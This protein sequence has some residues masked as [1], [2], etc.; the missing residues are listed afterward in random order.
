MPKK[1]DQN[2]Q[3][4]VN[5][6]GMLGLLE[7][8]T[9]NKSQVSIK[10]LLEIT[11]QRSFGPLILI[12]GLIVVMPVVGDFPGATSILNIGVL[13]TLMQLLL[14]RAHIWLPRWLSRVSLSTKKLCKGIRW[15]QRPARLIDHLLK[16]R[17]QPFIQGPGAYAILLSC[18]ALTPVI[19]VL[20]VI[21]FTAWSIGVVWA[22][23]GLAL[24]ADDGLLSLFG[25]VLTS[26]IIGLV[27]IFAL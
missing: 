21:P 13:L 25:M 24:I 4:P 23:F 26:V 2:E 10:D 18:I 12:A 20:E 22:T 27:L 14:H 16:P 15:L 5:I 9:E 3:A 11:G 8:A 19:P 7:Q 6:G 17:L 1:K